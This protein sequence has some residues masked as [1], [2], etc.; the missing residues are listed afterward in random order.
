M[1]N[2]Q[3]GYE[4]RGLLTAKMDLPFRVYSDREK[5]SAFTNA[6]LEKVRALPGVQSAGIGSNAPL[7]GGW[8]TGFFRD[9]IA[10]PTPSDMP[11]ADLEVI[12]GDYFATFKVPLLRGRTFNS[13]DKTDSPRVIIIDQALAEQIFPGEDPIGKRLSVDEGNDNEGNVPAEIVGIVARMRFR[14]ID[15]TAPMPVIYCPITQAQRTSLGL[16]VRASTGLTSLE[17]P[18][19]DMVSSIDPAQPVFDLRTMQDRVKETWG[20]QRLLT[21]LF[22]VFAGLALLLA[23]IGLYGVLSYNMLKRV[24][25]IGVRLALGA[26]PGQIRGLILSHGMQLLIIGAAIGL[27]GAVAFSRLLQS[28]LFEVRAADPSTY[29]GVGSILFA[30]TFVAC[31]IPARRA[32]RVD[33][34]V[35]LRED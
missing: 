30:A 33:P 2:L 28:I 17:K 11:S 35:A 9:G 7:M 8:Q 3:L 20:T 15:E 16:F 1:Q 12:T 14:A 19:R 31:W 23:T 5:V 27:L 13:G 25:E 10:R 32:S 22:A 18:I 26:R 6:L 24:R 21:S 29:L 4:P 34:I